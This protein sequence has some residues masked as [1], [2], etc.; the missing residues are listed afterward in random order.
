LDFLILKLLLHFHLVHQDLLQVLQ[1]QQKLHL[2]HQLLKI[3]N[4]QRRLLNFHQDYLVVV[5]LEV[6]FLFHLLLEHLEFHRLLPHQNLHY[7]QDYLKVMDYLNN[8]HLHLH[9]LK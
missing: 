6:Y 5:P 3:L 7:V 2:H 4:F 1:Y 8:I 9:P